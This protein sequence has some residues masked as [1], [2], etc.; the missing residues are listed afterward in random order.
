MFNRDMHDGNRDGAL[1]E[2]LDQLE[3]DEGE[4]RVTI[5]EIA[6]RLGER[7]LASLLLVPA[8]LLVSPLSS[9]PGAPTF[10]GLV[11]LLI[12]AQMMMGR[13]TLWLPRIVTRRSVAQRRMT[14]AVGFLRPPVR[15]A[16]CAIR[17]RLSPLTSRPASLITLATCV[18]LAVL[19]PAMEIVPM[20][21]SVAALAVALFA[22]GLMANDGLFVLFG[23]GIAGTMAAGLVSLF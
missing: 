19:F 21:S 15:W 4:A 6:A 22:V 20:L 14:R 2:I 12:A 23:F 10:T 8:L 1:S 16:E 13:R 9:I 11:I 7:S 5:G 3:R 17:P 18:S